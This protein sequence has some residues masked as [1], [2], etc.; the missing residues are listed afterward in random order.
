MKL[1]WE[2][3]FE[4]VSTEKS[5]RQFLNPL[6][7]YEEE[8][9]TGAIID[10]GCGQSD[11]LLDYANKSSK[12]YAIDNDGIQ[13]DYLRK[14]A[15]VIST[16]N[17]ENWEFIKLNFPVD[18]LPKDKFSVIILSNILHFFSFEQCVEIEKVVDNIAECG[19]M[20]YISVHSYKFYMNDPENPDNNEY[21]KH[22]FK[23]EDLKYIFPKEKYE[24]M[25]VAEI[26][27]IDS[28][29]EIEIVNKWIDKYLAI[30]EITD[31]SIINEIKEDYLKNKSQSDIQVIFRKL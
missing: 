31:I 17:L 18:A 5:L 12:I 10:I 26:D 4:E 9:I 20:I 13:L 23:I 29:Q 22:Y 27:K 19:T 6:R 30:N 16:N 21:F 14:R 1:Y 11:F 2:T 25:F 15:K 3:L 24:Y 7:G 8:F 28:K